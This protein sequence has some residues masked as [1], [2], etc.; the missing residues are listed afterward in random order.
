[1]H[2]ESDRQEEAEIDHDGALAI[3]QTLDPSG[4]T[5]ALLGRVQAEA[6]ASQAASRSLQAAFDD[7]FDPETGLALAQL[8]L[9]D[10]GRPERARDVLRSLPA[11]LPAALDAQRLGL[12]AS[13][14]QSEGRTNEARALL[15]DAE[16]TLSLAADGVSGVL[17]RLCY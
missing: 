9:S 11:K 10:L 3:L 14:A 17:K 6:G 1:M 16:T 4:P 5:L 8:L 13:L 15:A 12:Q 7:G 2:L